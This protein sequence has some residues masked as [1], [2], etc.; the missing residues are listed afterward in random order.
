MNDVKRCWKHAETV[1]SD[2]QLSG[3]HGISHWK[4]VERFGLGMAES[5]PDIDK[6]VISLFACFHDFQR[7]D[8]GRDFTHG[9]RA[10][11]ALL[12]LRSSLLC[13]LTD[14]QFAQL[15][16]ACREHTERT[17]P[18]GDITID[19]CI[20]ADRLDLSRVNI[21]PDPAKMLTS[22]G[23]KLAAEIAEKTASDN[24]GSI[25]QHVEQNILP[26][27]GNVELATQRINAAVRLAEQRKLDTLKAFTLA[28]YAC[29]AKPNLL[30]DQAITNWFTTDEIRELQSSLDNHANKINTE[31]P[32]T[33]ILNEVIEKP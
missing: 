15:T 11:E 5:N 8:N 16:Q 6:T 20:D 25:I 24:D 14:K 21:T 33:K 7:T 3:V 1:P 4:R 26:L 29:L 17:S 2:V 19:T 30:K 28:S 32:F 18:S 22:Q 23:S 13:F 12:P 27:C 10:A 31:D 9:P